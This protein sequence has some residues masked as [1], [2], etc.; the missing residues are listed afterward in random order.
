M[1]FGAHVSI[2][3]G[4]DK[5]PERAADLGCE[6]FQIFSRS[7]QGGPPPALT[8]DLVAQLQENVKKYGQKEFY[9]HTPYIINLASAE[10]RI[11]ESSVRLIKED[12][13]R[14]STLGARYVMTHVGSAKDG[15]KGEARTKVAENLKRVLDEAH[16]A[17]PS[18][19]GRAEAEL[20]IEMSAGAGGIIG[21]TFEDLAFFMHELTGYTV[22]ICFDTAHMFASGYDI[23]DDARVK[24]TLDAFDRIVGLAHLKLSHCNDSKVGLGEKKDRHEH[25]GKGMIGLAGFE[26][27]VKEPRL[28]KINFVCETEHDAVAEDIR[29]MKEFRTKWER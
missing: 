1:L 23:R 26:A 19:Q 7:P 4:I 25:L 12:L 15:D 3:G 14:A 8:A 2:A 9:V 28:K 5:A 17:D 20:L 27:L 22:G 29:I 24:E 13:A 11:E 10:K 18:R 16:T 21:D 6:V